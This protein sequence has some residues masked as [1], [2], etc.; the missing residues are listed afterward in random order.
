MEKLH[1]G[2]VKGVFSG[3]Y[4]VLS[5]RIKKNSDEL[6]E[7][8]NL[9]LSFLTAPKVATSNNT[10]EESFGWDSRDYLRNQILGK[11]VKYTIDYKNNDKLFGQVFL[12]GKNINIDVVKNG[13]AKIGFTGKHNE[14][15]A[16]GEYYAKLQAAEAEARKANLNLWNGDAELQNQHK[17]KVISSND[18]EFDADMF[19][20]KNK[21]KELDGIVDFVINAS[22]YVVYLKDSCTYIKV[23]LRFVAIPSSKDE[24]VYKAG[25][26]Y[27]ERSVLHKDVKV[28]LFS[29]ENKSFVSDVIEKKGSMSVF[30]LKNGYSK[31]FLGN[32]T[33]KSEE[34][35]ALKEAQGQARRERL[36][37]WRFEKEEAGDDDS[38]E[39]KEASSLN[40]TEMSIDCVF[41]QV[42]SGDS[43]SVKNKK[44]GEIIRIFLSHIKAPLLA[45]PGTE[46]SDQPWAWQAR[47]FIRKVCVGKPLRCEFD[48]FRTLPK[49]GKKMYFY[50]VFR[51][52]GKETDTDTNMNFDR[53]LN[54]EILE[55]GYASF[56]N[57][58]VD[59]EISKHL[60]LYSAAEKASKEKKTGIHSTK[61]PG[62]FNFSDL[63]SANREKKKNFTKF[64][65][66]KKNLPCV[67]E[68]C[69]SSTKLKLRI[70][71]NNC[72]IPFS[73]LGIKSVNKDKNNTELHD[74]LFNLG[75]EYVNEHTLQREGTCD[76]IQADRVGNYFGF[77]HLKGKNFALNLLSEGLAV[78]NNISSAQIPADYKKAEKSAENEKKNIWK[79]EA[80]VNFLKDIDM[81]S[82]PA[83]FTEKHSD[84]KIRVTDYIDL[85]NFYVNILPIKNLQIIESVLANYTSGKTKGVKVEPPVN[86]GLLCAARY[87]VDKTFYRAIITGVL[88]DEKYEVE[89][90][91]YGTVDIVAGTDLIKLDGSIAQY[92][93]QAVLCELAYMKFSQNTMKK[94]M[95][96]FPDF[97][98]LELELNAKLCYTYNA[99]VKEKSGVLIYHTQDKK[100]ANSYHHDILKLGLAKLDKSKKIPD[101]F[102]ELSELDSANE[103]KNIGIWAENDVSDDEGDL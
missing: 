64:L 27:A 28:V 82:L 2:L 95:D 15:H 17:R 20:E 103:N 16:K 93:A 67:I 71:G 59:D 79:Y 57:P 10:D 43:I 25:K 66:G 75:L 52:P 86:K 29:L 99:E 63:I 41:Y 91:D 97:V 68:Y 87:H 23:S 46:E 61:S 49:D 48:Y 42:H 100:N 37:V 26:A 89:F 32:N 84:I 74:K 92:E 19:F 5:G 4:I 72:M 85:N 12:E 18:L 94:A 30:I 21:E 98:N 47:E 50:S 53:N 14:A 39:K 83:K 24:G 101:Y 51:N 33:Y 35:A 54:V 58:R 9:Y 44:T 78:L 65:V 31:L 6:P 62:L 70:D 88:K 11:V 38:K 1:D 96:K 80:I 56:I 76:I 40:K 73:L 7:E 81:S 102:K 60:D 8:K 13:Y 3:D 22:C 55:H 34:L 69:F 36:R 77:L 90:I 45:K